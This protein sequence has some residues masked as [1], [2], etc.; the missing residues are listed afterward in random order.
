MGRFIKGEYYPTFPEGGWFVMAGIV[1][2][3]WGCYVW[4]WHERGTGPLLLQAFGVAA[5]WIGMP[6]YHWLK[7]ASN[8]PSRWTR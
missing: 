4:T 6:V 3:V 8:N 5:A 7:S 1:A 2:F